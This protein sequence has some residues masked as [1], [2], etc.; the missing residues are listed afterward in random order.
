MYFN[1]IFMVYKALAQTSYFFN[2]LA[3]LKM[4]IISILQMRKLKLRKVTFIRSQTQ[5]V[6]KPGLKSLSHINFLFCKCW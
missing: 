3:I 5:E 6:A 2:H 4:N 1:Y